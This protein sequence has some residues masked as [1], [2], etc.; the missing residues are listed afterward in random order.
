MI[1]LS[2]AKSLKS[3][4]TGAVTTTQ[5]E[6]IKQANQLV[7]I[8]NK[9]SISQLQS[10]MTISDKLAR[11]NH[12]RY[13]SWDFDGNIGDAAVLTFQGDVYQGLVA[14]EL[15]RQQLEYCQQKIMILSGLYGVL[16][17]LDCIQPYRLEMGTKLANPQGYNLY[18]YWRDFI[19]QKINRVIPKGQALINL[20]SKEYFSVINFKELTT[21][22]ITPIF[23]DQKNDDYKV[24]SFYAKKARG[25]ITRFVLERQSMDIETL[26]QFDY[27]NYYYD[28]LSSTANQLVFKRDSHNSQ[29]V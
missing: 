6:F 28:S 26:K 11:L 17:P 8:L 15:T 22:V 16:R 13:Q 20:A 9:Q 3:D 2:P 7:K 4:V 1:L 14:S 19:T 10:L 27:A 21:E 24:I 25:L 12:A 5:P 18:S 23:K 29:A